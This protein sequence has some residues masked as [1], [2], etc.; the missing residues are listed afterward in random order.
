MGDTWMTIA[1]DAKLFLGEDE[2]ASRRLG[3]AIALNRN[4]P[5]THFLLAAALA[6]LGRLEEARAAVQAGL[7][8][9]ADFTVRRYVAGAAS[10]HPTF[11]AQRDRVVA[12]LRKAGVPEG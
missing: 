5:Y 9:N 12:G 6:N 3:N 4:N 8:L 11:L 2:E 7:T 10:D 1:G